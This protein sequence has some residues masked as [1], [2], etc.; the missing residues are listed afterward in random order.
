MVTND[1]LKQ[2]G[3]KRPINH[4]KSPPALAIARPRLPAPVPER[5][6]APGVRPGI[7]HEPHRLVAR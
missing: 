6:R 3:I 4:D 2:R 1:A 5:L 7:A